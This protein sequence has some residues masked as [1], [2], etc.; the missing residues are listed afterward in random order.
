MRFL[1]PKPL[2]G[3]RGFAGEVGIIV[4]GVLIALV[5][6][7]AVEALHWRSETATLRESLHREIRDDQWNAALG[8]MI[9]GCIRQRIARLDEELHRSGTAWAAD[10]I[11]GGDE[12]RWSALPMALKLPSMEGFYTS[13][14]WQTALASGELAHMPDGERN[15]NSY[16]YQAIDDLRAFSSQEDAL[17]AHLQPL[18]TDQQLDNRQRLEFE[19]D[20]ASID[21][22]N[23]LLTIYSRKFLEGT[24]RAGIVPR[25]ENIDDAYRLARAEYGGCAIP[26]GST[27]DA[28]NPNT[29]ATKVTAED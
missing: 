14:N 8:V 18:A 7:Q 16:A 15:G 24:G 2:H 13:G 22:L 3:W 5:A 21:H 25:R 11:K 10:P 12:Q 4:L 28:L 9:S 26:L 20:L 1:L 19:A 27:E 23:T 29:N 17:A 6:Q